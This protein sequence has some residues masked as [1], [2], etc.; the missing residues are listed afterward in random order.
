MQLSYLLGAL[1]S[2]EMHLVR[3][4]VSAT[5]VPLCVRWTTLKFENFIGSKNK[6]MILVNVCPDAVAACKPCL[7]RV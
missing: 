5:L 4:V 3:R 2:Q 1:C 6:F 7:D